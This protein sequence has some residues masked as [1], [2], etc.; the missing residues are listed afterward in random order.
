MDLLYQIDRMLDPGSKML[1]HSITN[2]GSTAVEM[3]GQFQT[4][5][6]V[7]TFCWLNQMSL[8]IVENKFRLLTKTYSF[9]GQN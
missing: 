1:D 9:I 6:K 7:E 2:N 4:T 8:T 5:C 3:L